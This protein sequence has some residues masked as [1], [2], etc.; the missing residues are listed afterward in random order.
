[1]LMRALRAPGS[2][3]GFF[4]STFNSCK[5][6]LFQGTFPEALDIVLPGWFA[7]LRSD[8][9]HYVNLTDHTI[10]LPN[11]SKFM[12]LGLDDP[13]K[14]RGLKFSTILLNE[15]NFVDYMT[16]MTLRGRLSENIAT[17]DGGRLE[18]KMLFDLN[19]TVKTSWDYQVFV[20]GVVPGEG[21]PI[22]RHAE[23]YRYLTINAIDNKSNLPASLFEDFESMT[24][25]QRLRDEH[26]MWSEDNP[27]ALFD[28]STIA[29]R[30]AD[31]EDMAR[32][33]VAIDPAGTVD[34][35]GKRTPIAG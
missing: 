18:T 21:K 22:P 28:L 3:H 5:R 11:G 6:N 27:N 30:H 8:P 9:A 2:T 34:R 1:M 20:E 13:D 7:D 31:P 29:R 23:T 33:V 35:R 24:A 26:G 10:T 19:P 25:A 15:A 12:F 32:L 16:V 4:D 17:I 14:V